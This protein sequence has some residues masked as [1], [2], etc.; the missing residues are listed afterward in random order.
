MTKERGS[1]REIIK[2][3]GEKEITIY[4]TSTCPFCEA[5]KENLDRKGIKYETV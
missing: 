3:V 2:A 4:T 1:Q 5:A